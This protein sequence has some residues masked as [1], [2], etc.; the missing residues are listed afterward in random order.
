MS[1]GDLLTNP[2]KLL[3]PS[4]NLEDF[5]TKVNFLRN[6][7]KYSA[8]CIRDSQD[9]IIL[10]DSLCDA[11]ELNS[12]KDEG[13][14][15]VNKSRLVS[16]EGEKV[17]A[18]KYLINGQ[19]IVAYLLFKEGG[20]FVFNDF[21][22]LLLE[23]VVRESFI[24]GKML[25]MKE[26]VKRVKDNGFGESI[27]P[28]FFKYYD[29]L[30]WRSKFDG[31]RRKHFK[32]FKVSKS[33][34]FEKE[35]PS[36]KIMCKGVSCDP[37]NWGERFWNCLKNRHES[38]Y[39]SVRVILSTVK[40]RDIDTYRHLF[41]V[42]RLSGLIASEMGFEGEDLFWIELAGL[43][44]DVGKIVLPFELLGKPQALANPEME[45]LKL[46]VVYSYEILKEN[47]IFKPA[48]DYVYQHH[49]RVDGSGYPLGLS[50]DRI[51]RGSFPVIMAD[52]VDAMLSDRPYRKAFK[53]IKVIEEL[54]RGT[55]KK[56]PEEAAETTIKLLTR[57]PGFN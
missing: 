27:K 28:R 18:F 11:S 32:G 37:E 9:K 36:F 20:N 41:N 17:L 46:H 34:A 21:V 1:K 19:I 3:L 6:V 47:E 50:G 13:Q 57:N 52:I 39:Y 15:T 56:Y 12:L 16:F 45:V 42:G 8:L 5:S 53:L 40:S 26:G 43:L 49:E 30:K 14:I 38:L 35:R 22:E 55:G 23:S 7:M 48:L 4:C 31:A 29:F 10:L 33:F 44:H 24:Y 2:V 51:L 54:E 25:E